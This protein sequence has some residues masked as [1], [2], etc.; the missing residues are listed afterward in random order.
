MCANLHMQRGVYKRTLVGISH[1]DGFGLFMAE[2]A[3]AGD[4]VGEYTGHITGEAESSRR[5][6]IYS[7]CVS[8]YEFVANRGDYLNSH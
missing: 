5:G 4:Y 6:L 2:E 7:R 3:K 8:F 1:V